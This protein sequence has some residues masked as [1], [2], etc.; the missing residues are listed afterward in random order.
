MNNAQFSLKVVETGWEICQCATVLPH[1]ADD[2]LEN[3]NRA[4]LAR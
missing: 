3:I 4:M 1:A 2:F